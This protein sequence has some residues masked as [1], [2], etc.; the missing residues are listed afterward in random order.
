MT[1][2]ERLRYLRQQKLNLTTR[3]F[4]ASINMSGGAIT[5]MEKGTRNIT[6]RTIRDICREYNINS[7]WLINGNEPIFKNSIDSL[8]INSEVKQLVI[9]YNLLN[10]ND[11]EL[12]KNMIDS[13]A[14]KIQ[15]KHHIDYDYKNENDPY[16][17]IPYDS[18]EFNKKY[19]P[20]DSKKNGKTG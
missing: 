20:D 19:F 17:D 5:N 1:I 16:I 7:D 18:D 8:D 12:I 15:D 9:K 14:E 13:L 2:N 6:E 10:H 11:K 4:G 3:A